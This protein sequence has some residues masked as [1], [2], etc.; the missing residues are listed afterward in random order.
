ML[1]FLLNLP[2]TVLGLLAALLSVPSS[3]SIRV[4][5][6]TFIVSVRKLWWAVG[7]LKGARAVTIGQ[8]ILL[9]PK[10]EPGDLAHERV[11]VAQYQRQ[12]LI[13]PFLYAFELAKNGYRNNRYEQEAYAVAGKYYPPTGNTQKNPLK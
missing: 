9:G 8:A 5:K 4:E 11:H 13:H 2:W 3:T 6:F 10:I 7:Y 1:S 12:P